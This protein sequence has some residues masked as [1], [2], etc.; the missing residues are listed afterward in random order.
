[1]LHGRILPANLAIGFQTRNGAVMARFRFS[2][3]SWIC[4]FAA[5]AAIFSFKSIHSVCESFVWKRSVCNLRIHG[6]NLCINDANICIQLP[7]ANHATMFKS[8]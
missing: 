3:T 5:G 8:I 2:A 7:S 1:M 6:K 4:E